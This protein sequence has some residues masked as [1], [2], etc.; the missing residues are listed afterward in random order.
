MARDRSFVTVNDN[1]WAYLRYGKG[2]PLLM[3][4]GITN[5]AD[6]LVPLA[7]LLS[8]DFEVIIPD[9]PGCGFTKRLKGK[10]TFQA[11]S[12]ELTDF[13]KALG[14]TKINL[15]GFSLGARISLETA[16]NHPDII[17]NQVVQ[18]PPWRPKS[19]HLDLLGH[20]QLKLASSPK[21]IQAVQKNPDLLKKI[22]KQAT[23]VKPN[24]ESLLMKYENEITEAAS[25]VDVK[26]SKE[27]YESL[28]KADFCGDVKKITKELTEK[29]ILIAP[30][31]DPLIPVTEM[32]DLSRVFY[33]SPMVIV[34]DQDH[35]MALEVPELM[36]KIIIDALVYKKST[37]SLDMHWW[38]P[39]K[40]G[41]RLYELP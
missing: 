5:Y 32:I 20:I 24:A 40:A 12:A 11:V 21:I 29:T 8:K 10:T 4:H 36:A 22:L 30:E 14:F 19:I 1:V 26:A 9:L 17:E 33:D 23:K 6:Y 31:N 18:S 41:N 15:F 7:N 2:Q 39:I 27:F 13:V 16:L 37:E 38:R 28:K 34:F 25:M 3:L 35:E